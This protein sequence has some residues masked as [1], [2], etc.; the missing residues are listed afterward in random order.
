MK[1]VGAVSI[2]GGSP[3]CEAARS[4][5]GARLLASQGFALQ[6]LACT[7]PAGC[8]CRYRKYPDR[9]ADDDRRMFGSTQRGT[10]YGMNERREADGR[11]RADRQRLSDTR[12]AHIARTSVIS[13]TVASG[14]PRVHPE[15][16]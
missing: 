10:L 16:Q 13:L 14:R 9:L 4:L 2:V 15:R 5:K 1:G 6:V 11:R 12:Q 8:K 7:M 3:C